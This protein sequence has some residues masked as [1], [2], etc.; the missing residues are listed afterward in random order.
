[1]T[2]TSNKRFRRM[3]RRICRKEAR[4]QFK[5]FSHSVADLVGGGGGKAC[6]Q[7]GGCAMPP[8]PPPPREEIC[9]DD[10]IRRIQSKLDIGRE[11]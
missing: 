3:V 9:V 5:K 1:M 6:G 7:G 10:L 4:K 11:F 8:H 2:D